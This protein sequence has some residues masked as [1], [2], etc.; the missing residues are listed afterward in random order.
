MTM[1]IGHRGAAG[2]APENT[3]AAFRVALELGTDGIEFDVQRTVDSHLVVFHDDDVDRVTDGTGALRTLRLADLKTLDAGGH[4]DPRFADERVPTLHETLNLLRGQDVVLHIELK[5]PWYFDGIEQ[6]V[7]DMVYQMEMVEQVWIRSFYHPALH[8]VHAIA[9]EFQI[10]ELWFDQFPDEI[11]YPM[12]N[13]YHELCTAAHI[14]RLHAQGRQVTA[15]T[16]ND[17][18]VA[19]KLIAMGI[20]GLTTDFPDRLL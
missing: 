19:R 15:W 16:V 12:L 8:T 2:L 20:D 7:V 4:F 9:P 11:T 17:V 10:S 1:I 5:S 6:Q 3:L 13:I 14:E 18:D